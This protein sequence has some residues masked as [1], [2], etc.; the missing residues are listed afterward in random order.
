MMVYWIKAPVSVNVI[1]NGAEKTAPVSKIS[2]K[3][4]LLSPEN[5]QT[6]KRTKTN[7][8]NIWGERYAQNTINVVRHCSKYN[9]QNYIKR[10]SLI[11]DMCGT[12]VLYYIALLS[13]ENGCS[14]ILDMCMTT[15]LYTLH[16]YPMRMETH[17]MATVYLMIIMIMWPILE[18]HD[19]FHWVK[20][21]NQ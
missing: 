14:L 16:Y 2:K 13:N 21:H 4:V 8:T 19:L 17:K 7:V 1:T 5:K 18:T 10:W 20:Q 6:I 3:T 12:T 11:L 15:V 9:H